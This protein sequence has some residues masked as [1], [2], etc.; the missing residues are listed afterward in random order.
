MVTVR[1]A[2]V[3][4]RSRAIRTFTRAFVADPF[5]RWFFPDDAT[6]EERAAGFFGYLFDV[7]LDGGL[8]LVAEDGDGVSAWNPPGGVRHDPEDERAMWREATER[9][10]PDELER[11]DRFDAVTGP[12]HPPAPHWYLGVVGV[13]PERQGSGLG[14]AVIARGLE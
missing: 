1:E 7:R 5:V 10:A 11:I 6:Y 3:S 9:F 14:R 4:D 2:T 12:M 13:E 8:V